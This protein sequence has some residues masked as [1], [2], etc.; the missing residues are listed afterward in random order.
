M[1]EEGEKKKT[2]CSPYNSTH[3][4]LTTSRFIL[5]FRGPNGLRFLKK[6]LLTRHFKKFGGI[7][8][9]H[10]ILYTREYLLDVLSS[11]GLETS[12]AGI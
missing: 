11:A 9:S 12:G 4:D 6:K 1:E 7:N 10:V 5:M 8:R 3:F 2:V